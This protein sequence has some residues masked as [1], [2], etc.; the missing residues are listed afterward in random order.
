MAN[1]LIASR[2]LRYAASLFQLDFLTLKS[3]FFNVK[4]TLTSKGQVTIPLG[5]RIRL[6]LKPGDVLEFD[7]SAPFIKATKS[8]APESWEQFGR[9]WVDPFPGVPIAA[10]LDE[11][12]GPVELPSGRP[13][14]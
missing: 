4:A 7:E 1:P 11:L 6:H 9:G 10:A 5:V 2:L 12:R 8:I 3:Y 14:S 13:Q